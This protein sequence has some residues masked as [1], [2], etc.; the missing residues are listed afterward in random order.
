MYWC[1]F[2]RALP[3]HALSFLHLQ[4]S[5]RLL[6]YKN[7]MFY[8]L[9]KYKFLI[10]LD[11]VIHAAPTI[12]F[13][14][15]CSSLFHGNKT[16]HTY[17]IRFRFSLATCSVPA[18]L[19]EYGYPCYCETVRGRKQLVVASSIWLFSPHNSKYLRCFY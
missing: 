17:G 16:L 19:S 7:S 10:A 5:L 6:V 2:C 3:L 12:G 1:T 11:D 15:T 18:T 9:Q 8:Q 14:S 4:L 13:H